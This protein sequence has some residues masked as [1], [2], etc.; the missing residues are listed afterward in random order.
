[1]A[2]EIAHQWW[3]SQVLPQGAGAGWLSEAF[4]EYS[5]FLFV[6]SQKGE[7]GLRECLADAKRSYHL[8]SAQG[9]EEPISQTDPLDQ[10]AA[11]S[12]VVYSKGAYILHMLREVVGRDQLTKILRTF[13]AEH[14][15]RAAQI[16]D[17]RRTAEQVSGKRLDWFFDQ[18]LNRTGT[19]E[20]VYDYTTTALSGGQYKTTL[21][22]EQQ[23]PQPY[24]APLLV[25]LRVAGE[26]TD[27]PEE[28]REGRQVL[29]YQTAAEPTDVDFDPHDDLLLMT[30]KRRTVSA[31]PLSP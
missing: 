2:H 6:E 31:G 3:G 7:S 5:S 1:V 26:A 30:P 13:A 8:S 14:Q 17:F 21:V 27:H 20:L 15:G 19:I 25:R 16:A 23:T 29:E 28:L 22:L 12:G 18:W 11:Y 10:T 24:R 9:P 4:A